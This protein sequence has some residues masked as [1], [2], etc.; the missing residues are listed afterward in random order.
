MTEENKEQDSSAESPLPANDEKF[1]LNLGNPIES[2][3]AAFSWLVVVI[4]AA[5]SVA[6]AAKLISTVVGLIWLAVLLGI[7][8]VLIVKGLRY[9]L[10]SPDEDE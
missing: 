9:E 6:L 4:L 5:A 2:E 3:G 8:A 1:G 10:G 7:V